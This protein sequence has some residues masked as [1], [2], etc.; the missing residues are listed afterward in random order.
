MLFQIPTLPIVTGLNGPDVCDPSFTWQ[1]GNTCGEVENVLTM[2]LH[3]VNHQPS[4]TQIEPAHCINAHSKFEG[5]IVECNGVNIQN[6]QLKLDEVITAWKSW[7]RCLMAFSVLWALFISPAN[8]R[9][10][11]HNWIYVFCRCSMGPTLQGAAKANP[12]AFHHPLTGKSTV[13]SVGRN[14]TRSSW[15]GGNMITKL[16]GL[17]QWGKKCIV[18]IL[19]AWSL[20]NSWLGLKFEVLAP[21]LGRL[22]TWKRVT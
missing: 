12:Q 11:F 4:H 7:N 21:K 17:L 9:C 14:K 8:F 19:R 5:R 10:L 6:K 13:G 16:P 20:A 2:R 22:K 18:C 1:N 3:N 15:Y